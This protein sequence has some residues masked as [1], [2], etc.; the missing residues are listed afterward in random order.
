MPRAS[1]SLQEHGRDPAGVQ[2]FTKLPSASELQVARSRN[3]TDRQGF[4]P[5]PPRE[6]REI[7]SQ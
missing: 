6:I 4:R 2:K 7:L 1:G 3:A 5:G